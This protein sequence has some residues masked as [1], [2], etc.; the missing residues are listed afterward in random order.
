M[1]TALISLEVKAGVA[2]KLAGGTIKTSGTQTYSKAVELLANT[3]L[4][5]STVSTGSTLTGLNGLTNYGLTVTGNA[6]FGDGT[7]AD[8]LTGLTT[9]SVSGNAALNKA[10][11]NGPGFM[12]GF[13]RAFM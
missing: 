6:A 3:T 7:D 8:A 13:R 1:G 10:A 11:L 2:V 4:E 12:R 9:L 5:G